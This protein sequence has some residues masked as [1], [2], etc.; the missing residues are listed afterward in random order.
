MDLR[1]MVPI[2]TCFCESLN[3]E[4]DV[5][6]P[7]SFS[8]TYLLPISSTAFYIGCSSPRHSNVCTSTLNV[9]LETFGE[10]VTVELRLGALGTSTIVGSQNST[11]GRVRFQGLCAG[12]YFMA[13]GNG[14]Q[15]GVT[16][17]RTFSSSGTY[18]SR[19]TVQQGSG[20]V[21]NRSRKSL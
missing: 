6:K 2:R 10:G 9:T 7:A 12:T 1:E 8:L 11:G 5:T 3:R 16:P 18:N 20:N 15:V 19:I 13:I 4:R 17:V 14:D 21:S